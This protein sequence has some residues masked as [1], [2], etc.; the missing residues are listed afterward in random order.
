MTSTT[1]V[2]RGGGVAVV[3]H[4]DGSGLPAVLHWGADLADADAADLVAIGPGPVPHNALDDPWDLTVLPTSGDG[5]LGTPGI[6]AHRAGGHTAPAG[7]R[8][9]RPRG[10]AWPSCVPGPPA[11]RPT[12][13]CGTPS[14]TTGSSP[15]R[16]P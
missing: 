14:T 2:L 15:S 12:S 3:L 8:P 1:I 16:R 6:A 5:W 7:P 13:S 4:H 10:R 9:C 11:S